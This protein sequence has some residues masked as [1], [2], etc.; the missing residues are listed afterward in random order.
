[1][2]DRVFENDIEAIMM[3]RRFFSY[4]PQSNR[5]TA[6]IRPSASQPPEFDFS[7]DTLVPSNPNKAYDMME[8]ILK[9]VDDY[10]FFEVQPDYAKNIIVG[11]GKVDGQTV[12]IVANQ[13]FVLAGCL[14]IKSS[15]KAARFVRFV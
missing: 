6:P 12:G 1:V 14:S 3:L 10:D 15:I 5:E 7:L 4:L 8:L 13:P 11:F 9:T 2:C